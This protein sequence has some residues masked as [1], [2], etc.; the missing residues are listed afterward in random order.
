MLSSVTLTIRTTKEKN[1]QETEQYEGALNLVSA[2]ASSQ[3]VIRKAL[4]LANIKAVCPAAA[5]T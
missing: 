5:V 3:S 2:Q 1:S 4:W